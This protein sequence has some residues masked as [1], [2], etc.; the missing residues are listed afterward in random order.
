MAITKN[1]IQTGDADTL[2]YTP[3]SV[4]DS[5]LFVAVSSEDFSGDMPITGMEFD[6]NSMTLVGV[7]QGFIG[8]APIETAIAYLVNPGT[9][10]GLI[11]VN[12]GEPGDIGI[13]AITLGNVDQSSVIDVFD[14]ENNAVTAIQTTTASTTTNNESLIISACGYGNVGALS[15]TGAAILAQVQPGSSRLAVGNSLNI[16]PNPYSHVWDAISSNRMSAISAAFNLAAAASVSVSV[17]E[18]RSSRVDS[19][20]VDIVVPFSA[21]VTE[22]RSARL[23]DSSISIVGNTLI[24]VTEVRQSR[25]NSSFIVIPDNIGAVVTEIKSARI[26]SSSLVTPLDLGAVVTEIKSARIN[27]SSVIIPIKLTVNP[28]NIIRAKR[29]NNTIRVRS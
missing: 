5:V 29:N 15:A 3:S 1:N 6:G 19:S 13:I 24:A 14:I 7:A 27:I 2:S 16:S 4:S 23:N 18:T 8:A 26:D 20:T 28:K 22:T 17:T 9:S 21:T 10:S 12:G 25:L 11:T